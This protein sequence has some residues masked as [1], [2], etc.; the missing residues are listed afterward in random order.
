MVDKKL[1]NGGFTFPLNLMVVDGSGK[2]YLAII[3]ARDIRI[4]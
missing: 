2:G 3:G 1:V 4:H